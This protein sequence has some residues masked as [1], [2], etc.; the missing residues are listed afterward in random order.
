MWPRAWRAPLSPPQ[1]WRRSGERSQGGTAPPAL[2]GW[3]RGSLVRKT[4]RAALSTLEQQRL[5]ALIIK[6]ATISCEISKAS[7]FSLQRRSKLSL[8]SQPCLVRSKSDCA[9]LAALRVG[10]IYLAPSPRRILIS[11]SRKSPTSFL[12]T[13]F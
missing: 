4:D 1:G 3:R 13:T 10:A 2:A 5:P 9:E 8:G 11:G 6:G 7:S 12:R